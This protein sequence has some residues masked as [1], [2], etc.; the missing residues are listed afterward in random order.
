MAPLSLLIA[1]PVSD[2]LLEPAMYPNRLLGDIFGPVVGVGAGA[3]MAL[4]FLL[5]GIL[6]TL[7]GLYGYFVPSIRNIETLVPDFAQEST[8]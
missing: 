4:L 1:G 3:G 8:A 5:A 7:S 2:R 6:V